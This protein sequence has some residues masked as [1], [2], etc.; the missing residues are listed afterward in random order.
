MKLIWTVADKNDPNQIDMN[1]NIPD[2]AD[3]DEID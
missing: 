1:Q 3:L 2:Q